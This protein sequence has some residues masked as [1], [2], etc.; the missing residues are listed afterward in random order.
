[1]IAAAA[2]L[3]AAAAAPAP[4]TTAEVV[5]YP[6]HARVTRVLEVPCTGRARAGFGEVT[7]AA[8]PSSFRATISRG[9][10]EGVRW[11]QRAR[12][13]AFAA[14]AEALDRALL[15]M[16]GRIAS[17][18]RQ[19]ERNEKAAEARAGLLAVAERL[20]T[21][22]MA[23]ARPDLQAWSAALEE[24]LRAG[25]EGERRRAAAE[26]ERRDL[27]RRRAAGRAERSALEQGA[28]RSAY[29]VDVVASC[30]AGG[31]A[32]VQLSY[33]VR[34]AGWTPSYELRERAGRVELAT[35]ATIQQTTGE[36]WQAARLRLSTAAPRQD[37]TPP[38]LAPLTVFAEERAERPQIEVRSEATPTASGAEPGAPAETGTRLQAIAQGLSVQVHLPD[39]ADVPGDGRQVRL[40]VGRASAAARLHLV[41]VPRL[42]ASVFRV[43]ELTNP[44]PFP[45][46]P[47][48]LDVYRG[49]D[50]L[51][52]DHLEQTPV[53][54][55]FRVG[56]GVED[57]VQVRRRV[58]EESGR[59]AGLLGG[60][61]HHRF[62]YR[63]DVES[64]LPGP[65]TL[66][67]HDH[68]PVSELKDV[69]VVLDPRTTGGYPLDARDGHLVWP[70]SLAPGVARRVELAFRVE[71]PSSYDVGVSE[72]QQP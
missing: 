13:A 16:D 54:G 22:Q 72:A 50:F 52:R 43:A 48:P 5:V 39:P 45:L 21:G 11:E 19:L 33:L 14:R 64:H 65:V 71:V 27:D 9:T 69:R 41:A 51:C 38:Q 58:L 55:H 4:V 56:L 29:L 3:L 67:L 57:R 49:G 37:A 7:P 28:E 20:V 66:E 10:V 6:D 53:G 61:R 31:G 70:L 17:L 46:L 63:F 68:V 23:R 1:V 25:L 34:G 12:Q 26:A 32:R 30:P 44:A 40:L 60:A 18:D 62:A 42:E 24:V 15:D 8:D 35:F 2:L 36:A 59:P 47:G